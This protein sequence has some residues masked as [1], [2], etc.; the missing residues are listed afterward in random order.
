MTVPETMANVLDKIRRDFYADR[1]REYKRDE[2]QLMRAIATYGHVC[3]EKGWNFE[4][5][6]IYQQLMKLLLD[7]RTAEADIKWLPRYLEGAIRRAI[8][9]QAEELSAKAKSGPNHA[10]NLV[11][12]LKGKMA[13]MPERQPSAVEVF[14]QVFKG[15]GQ[16]NRQ[17]KREKAATPAKQKELL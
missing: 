3:N 12:L 5:D 2:R 17:R 8:G 10:N 16:I 1:I 11:K 4:A 13:A 7:I 6:F 15:I 14:S 9:Q